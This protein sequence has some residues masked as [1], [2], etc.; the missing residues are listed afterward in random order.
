MLVMARSCEAHR[1]CRRRPLLLLFHTPCF[2]MVLC[3]AWWS[4]PTRALT[5]ARMMSLSWEGVE[6]FIKPVFDL[7]RAGHGWGVGT[8]QGG[9]CLLSKWQ[10]HFHKAIVETLR[11]ASEFMDVCCCDGTSHSCLLL[12]FAAA[13]ATKKCV[14]ANSLCQLAFPVEALRT[15]ISTL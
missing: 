13:L 5:S 4:V 12:L 15:A 11:N 7:I 6:L 10:L 14:A 3:Q 1:L 8:Y 9:I 2:S